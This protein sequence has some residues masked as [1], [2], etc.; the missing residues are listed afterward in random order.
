M[1]SRT[2]AGRPTI[3]ATCEHRPTIGGLVRPWINVE[4]RDGGIDFRAQHTRKVRQALTERLC[5]VC[6]TP[7]GVR[8]V[9]LGGPRHLEQLLFHEPPLHPECAVYTSRACPVVAGAV[10]ELPTGPSLAEGHRGDRCDVDGCDCGGWVPTP[11]DT[12]SADHELRPWFAVWATGY[13][14]AF[15]PDG[16][17]LGALVYPYQ[18]LWVRRV[19]EPGRGRCWERL[20][21][22]LAG[23]RAPD[24]AVPG[25][26]TLRA[27]ARGR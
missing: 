10:D 13:R 27:T 2:P 3:P 15:R 22:P 11:G 8:V 16:S 20:P 17:V 5:Q 18:V 21:D 6:G 4:L 24:L 1:S 19:S 23:Y 7:L 14:T 9:L 26:E 12:G 25:Q